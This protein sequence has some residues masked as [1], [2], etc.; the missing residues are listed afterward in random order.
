[1]SLHSRQ[2]RRV[3]DPLQRHLLLLCVPTLA[4]NTAC[5]LGAHF[6]DGGFVHGSPTLAFLCHEMA[7]LFSFISLEVVPIS[8]FPLELP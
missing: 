7:A 3:E 8:S 5:H 6:R 1:M 4:N 2:G